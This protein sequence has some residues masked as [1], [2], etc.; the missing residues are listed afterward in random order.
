MTTKTL[1]ILTSGGDASGMNAA[2]RA[3]MRTALN[4]GLETY[5]IY[6]GYQGLVDGG[7]RIRRV[8]WSA[9]SGILQRGGTAIGSARCAEFRTREGRRPAARNVVENNIDSLEGSG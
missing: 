2:V 6:D 5:A 1:A 4:H 3:V 7:D 8:D 9:T